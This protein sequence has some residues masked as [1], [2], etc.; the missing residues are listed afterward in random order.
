MIS[1]C[2]PASS[3][4]YYRLNAICAKCS[5][6]AW[7][8]VLLFSVAI[9]LA[10]LLG[11]W[12]NKRRINLAA[13]GIGVDFAQVVAMF[14]SLNFTWP[15]QLKSVFSSISLFNFNIQILQPEVRRFA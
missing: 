1:H 11:V 8:Y 4:G 9:M 10:M 5:S 2:V 14:V 6:G 12:L 13:L 15:T 7:V 3:Q